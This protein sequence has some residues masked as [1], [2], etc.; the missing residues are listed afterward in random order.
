MASKG[1]DAGRLQESLM[2]LD[3]LPTSAL[4][5]SSP[6]DPT[7]LDS[8]L[9]ARFESWVLDVVEGLQ[10]RVRVE[11][12]KLVKQAK[13]A[14]WERLKRLYLEKRQIVMGKTWCAND[15]HVSDERSGF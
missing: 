14:N 2:K 6:V 4:T 13:E 9:E 3:A 5:R 1:I 7:D 8:F 11:A 15:H 10:E 12:E